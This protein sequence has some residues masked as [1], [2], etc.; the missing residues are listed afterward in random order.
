MYRYLKLG[1]LLLL[2]SS[3]LSATSM[4]SQVSLLEASE[5]IRLNSQRIV[6]SYL[7]F[8]ANQKKFDE[9]E[10]ALTRL[11]ELNKQFELIDRST[12]DK[13]SKDV[14]NFL[15]YSKNKMKQLLDEALIK[16]GH[17]AKMLAYSEIMLNAAESINET[18]DYQLSEEEKMLINM[19]NISFLIEQ[20]T[21]YYMAIHIDKNNESYVDMLNSSISEMEKA[22]L[23][24]DDYNYNT[25]NL[26][27]FTKLK[28]NWI[29]L[30]GY[31][32]EGTKAEIDNIVLLASREIQ[33]DSLLLEKY[34]SKNQ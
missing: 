31:Y 6:V 21:K 9:R 14:L 27:L 18:L 1:T 34:H 28:N 23:I 20:M 5:N 7:S 17:P 33:K 24:L 26:A 2:L 10:L 3:L 25:Q 12:K 30:K 32:T 13:D 22:L 4:R 19:K 15:H 11:E 8:L 16:D 29:A